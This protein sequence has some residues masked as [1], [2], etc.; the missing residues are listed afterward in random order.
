MAGVP[1]QREGRTD[2]VALTGHFLDQPNHLCDRIPLIDAPHVGNDISAISEDFID[3]S[4]QVSSVILL[5]SS[6]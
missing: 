2:E 1:R 6:T 3:G 5:S 4:D